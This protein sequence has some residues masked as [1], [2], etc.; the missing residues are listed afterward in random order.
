[1]LK[2]LNL[3]L[4]LLL[5]TRYVFYY[6][7][8]LSHFLFVISICLFVV[9]WELI[10]LWLRRLWYYVFAIT[11][12]ITFLDIVLH[13]MLHAMGFIHE[14]NRYDRDDYIKVLYNNIEDGILDISRDKSIF[15]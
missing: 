7:K 9:L 6:R 2:M 13:E 5:K 11:F 3:P 15:N 10:L 14:Q 1:M 12:T 4:Q 8:T